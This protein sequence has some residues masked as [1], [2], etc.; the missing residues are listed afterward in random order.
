MLTVRV[1]RPSQLDAD[2]LETWRR[3][4]QSAA[5]L[6]S[7]F[8][9]P[10]FALVL[11]RVR[12]DVRV[13]VL[14]MSCGECGFFAF[15]QRGRAGRALGYGISDWQGIV[16][17]PR[18][19]VSA[20]EL[21]ASCGLAV[22]RFDHLSEQDAK[23]L[24]PRAQRTQS[25]IIDVGNDFRAYEEG[26]RTSSP[27]TFRSM[28]RKL[29]T[30]Q[31]RHEVEFRWNDPDRSAFRTL[32]EWKSRQY[33]Q[34]GRR[35]RFA[36]PWITGALEEL[37]ESDATGCAGVLSTLRLDGELAAVHFGI[38]SEHLLACWFPAFSSQWGAYS[39]GLQLFWMMA[40][41]SSSKGV[42]RLD[43]GKGDERF[44]QILA[45]SS[46]PLAEA[47]ITIP[48]VRAAA[49]RVRSAPLRQARRFVLAHEG[50]RAAAR[51][52]LRGIGRIRQPS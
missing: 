20:H 32:V 30:M 43:L 46:E 16:A 37:L 11:D 10:E 29:R 9:S 3:L 45:N 26:R 36:Q 17:S 23:R 15:Q 21:L 52:T 33:L 4:Q 50:L 13:A 6:A 27:G 25:W 31:R 5:H 24:A 42:S 19:E 14:Q 38:R 41:A 48:S 39:P 49:F 40:E 28:S 7:P 44:K 34:T 8:F 35:N 2:R 47:D 51:R 18:L 1:V 12:N 22:C